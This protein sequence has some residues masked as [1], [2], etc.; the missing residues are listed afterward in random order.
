MGAVVGDGAVPG[1]DLA[2]DPDV[3]ARARERLLE[4]HPVPALH[5]LRAGHAEAED[6]ASARE[7]VERHG[8][9]RGGSRLPRG[10]LHDRG[11]EPDALGVRPPPREGRQAIGP[12][13]LGGPDRVEAELF[14]L[15]DGFGRA[16]GWATGPVAGVVAELEL[17]R[18]GRQATA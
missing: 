9:H 13:C 12:V 14:G 16:R 10:H 7:V 11:A 5:H 1:P 4:R 8:R 18:H 15:G 3:L 17:L 6:E 2:Q